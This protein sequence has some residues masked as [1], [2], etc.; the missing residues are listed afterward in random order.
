MP[1]VLGETIDLLEG[2]ADHLPIPS[3]NRLVELVAEHWQAP[4]GGRSGGAL[5]L[6]L[7]RRTSRSLVGERPQPGGER[8]LRLAQLLHLALEP[9]LT[10]ACGLQLEIGR[11]SCRGSVE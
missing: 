9:A 4:G 6:G 10:S 1:P 3:P 2:I 8:R 11:A 5:P 7:C